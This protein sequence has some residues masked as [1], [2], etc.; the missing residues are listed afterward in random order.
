MDYASFFQNN[1]TVFFLIGGA[2]ILSIIWMVVLN[3]RVKKKASGYLQQHP[4]AAS[5]ILAARPQFGES[6]TVESVNGQRPVLFSK[7][8]RG[9]FHVE[10]GQA[11]IIASFSRTRPGVLYRSVTNTYP[12]IEFVIET[13]ARKTYELSF[14]QKEES[15]VLKEV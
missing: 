6:I 15:F 13:A 5:V 3:S 7:G 12:S 11:Q 14:E 1:Q 2:V 10:P 8:V 4:D 9:G